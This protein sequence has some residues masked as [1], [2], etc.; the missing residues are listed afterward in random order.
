MSV[1]NSILAYQ[2]CLEILDRASEDELG[3]RIKVDNM[4]AAIHL[5]SRIHYARKLH[6]QENAKTYEASHVMHGKSHYDALVVRIKSDGSAIYVYLERTDKVA[7]EIEPLSSAPAIE[8][9]PQKVLEY[10][11]EAM[12]KVVEQIIVRRRV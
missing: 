10:K 2:D 12:E 5:R 7:G 1:S 9:V 6:R 4:D 3:A 8:H 11:P